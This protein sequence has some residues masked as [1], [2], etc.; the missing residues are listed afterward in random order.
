MKNSEL[1]RSAFATPSRLFTGLEKQQI[2]LL[3]MALLQ[4]PCPNCGTLQDQISSADITLDDYTFGNEKLEH[5]CAGCKRELRVLVPFIAMGPPWHWGLV[6]DPALSQ[7][8]SRGTGAHSPSASA[9]Q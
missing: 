8:V 1:L 2:L 7:D 9:G 6:P 4:M 5:H 3:K